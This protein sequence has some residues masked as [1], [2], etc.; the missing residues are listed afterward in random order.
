MM[1]SDFF[2]HLNH[3]DLKMHMAKEQKRYYLLNTGSNPNGCQTFINGTC[4][5]S[6]Q[7]VLRAINGSNESE[8]RGQPVVIFDTKNMYGAEP[9]YKFLAQHPDV[10]LCYLC[11]T[12]PSD[13]PAIAQMCNDMR[14]EKIEFSTTYQVMDKQ[15]EIAEYMN[16]NTQ[17]TKYS[18]L[19]TKGS[20]V[21]DSKDFFGFGNFGKEEEIVEHKKVLSKGVL[22]ITSDDA[23]PQLADI[24]KETYKDDLFRFTKDKKWKD[25]AD[26]QLVM[27]DTELSKPLEPFSEIPERKKDNPEDRTVMILST[28][29]E[30]KLPEQVSGSKFKVIKPHELLS[31]G[32]EGGLPRPSHERR[33][34]ADRKQ[35]EEEREDKAPKRPKRKH[36]EDD[37]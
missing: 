10:K 22:V 11:Y 9:V 25:Y 1:I 16:F 6:Q 31:L 8:Y 14:F 27:V 36:D 20:F 24:I 32:I 30:A 3:L 33:K 2:V 28:N 19:E 17:T 4:D 35:K 23:K 18:S 7:F 26:Q 15:S 34:P 12:S 13:H 37:D 29:E 21:F 5:K